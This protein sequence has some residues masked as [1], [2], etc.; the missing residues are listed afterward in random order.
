MAKPAIRLQAV[1]IAF[2]VGIALLLIRAAQ[3]Q[4]IAG[5]GYA[6]EAAEQ[7]TANVVLPARRGTVFDRN[8][9]TL[10]LTVERYRVG[11]AP[12]E[13]TDPD[14]DIPEIA[15]HLGIS[16][17]EVRRRLRQSWAY[18]HGPYTSAQVQPLRSIRGVHLQGPELERFWPDPDLA[19]AVLGRPA[20]EGRNA[21]G[22]ERVFDSWLSGT[23]GSAV[24]LRDR[25]GLSYESPSRLG[26]FPV[27]G[28]DV[29]LTIDA[30][31]QEIVED[32][33]DDALQRFDA[34]GGDVIV[35]NPRSGEILA[36]ASRTID[37]RSTTTAFTGVFE[38]GSTAKLFTAAALLM[39]S[40]ATPADSVW[41]ENGEYQ[42]E[43]RTIT[44]VHEN[45]WLT[46][47]EVI[48]QSSNI[49]IV[50][51]GDRL[52][53][54]D[55]YE[56]LRN[57]GLGTPTGVEYPSESAGIL[58]RPHRWSGT[59]KGSLSM[60]YEVAVTPLQLA[61]A[62]AAIA[63]DGVL[64]RPTLIREIRGTSGELAYRHAPEPVR[65]VMSA[66]VAAD[67]RAVLT[68]VVYEGR[69]GET[70]ALQTYE[71]AG[72]TGTARR[73][74]SGGYIEGSYW[75]NFTSLFPASDP[76]MVMVVKLDDPKDTYAQATA[77]PMTRAV[78]EQVLAAQTE[79]LDHTRLSRSTPPPVDDRES[80][81]EST[82][83]VTAWPLTETVDSVAE[84]A[85]PDV[86]GLPLRAVARVLHEHR[87]RKHGRSAGTHTNRRC[88]GPTQSLKIGEPRHETATQGTGDQH[89]IRC[90]QAGRRET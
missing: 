31:L 57:F 11:V 69:T 72:K 78:L 17:R 51:L 87:L 35:L 21:G 36:V 79:A 23:P 9:V 49:G 68:G 60:G 86:L 40:L 47:H 73:A 88:P 18:F 74:G 81:S 20:G 43:H 53:P 14:A 85:V 33:L 54:D 80:E 25:K 39:K 4:L 70:A 13:L 62:Y 64:M 27:A 42:T 82:P 55:L 32:A 84:I 24:V 29:Y 7:Q 10:A 3:V 44:D 19:R 76:Q 38:P 66:E 61:Q 56:T 1:Q 6:E 77:A 50:K 8:G 37:S 41:C 22:V 28:H 46:L 71:V 89:T 67:L 26:A 52:S 5:S 48:E 12:N 15:R 59:T 30:A 45:G 65:R 16:R 75:A 58:H 90:R 63:N 2:T 83:Y 34:V